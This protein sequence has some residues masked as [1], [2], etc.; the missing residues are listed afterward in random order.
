MFGKG[1]CPAC[2]SSIGPDARECPDCG[3][4]LLIIIGDED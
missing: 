2:G 3:L 1:K 4:P